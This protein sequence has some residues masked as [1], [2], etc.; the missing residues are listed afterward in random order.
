MAESVFTPT[1]LE[2]LLFT[3]EMAIVLALVAVLVVLFFREVFPVPI[4]ALLSAVVLMATGILTPSEGLSGFSNEATIAVLAMFVLSAGIQ[5]TGAV[6]ALTRR[7]MAWAKGGLRRQIFALSVAA[8]PISGFVN[9]TPVVA[10]LIPAATHMGRE[11]KT[12]PSKLLMPLSSMAMLGGL[13]TV[14]G[15]STN[16]LGNAT[17]RRLGIVPFGFF[18]FTIVGAIALG[19]GLVYYLTIGA[20]LL[21]DR[22]SAD[23][24]NRFDLKGFI[25]EFVVTAEADVVGKTIREAGLGFSQGVQVLRLRRGGVSVDAP[26]PYFKIREGDELVLEAGREKLSKIAADHGLRAASEMKFSLGD[27]EGDYVTAEVVITTGSR[28]VGQTLRQIDF[29]NR[30]E[31]LVLA[32]RHQEHAEIGPLSDRRLRPGDVLLVQAEAESIERMRE[33]PDLY[34]TRERAKATYKSEKLPHALAIVAAVVTVSALG[35]LPISVAGLAGAALMV[36]VGCLDVSQF[37]RSIQLDIIF[38]LAGI[39]PLGLAFEQTG[40]ADLLAVGI[41]EV[42]VY[43]PPVVFLMLLFAVTSLVTEIMSNNASVV[44]LIP[45]AIGAAIALGIDARPVALTVMMA[46]STSMLTPIG[47][48]TNTMVLAPGNY[49]FSDYFRVGGMLNLILAIVIPLAIA[50][51]FPL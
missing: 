32:L 15:T 8:G 47:Y 51:R 7:L 29:R 48:Q 1:L 4:T 21:P 9:N 17:L 42:G 13:L 35:W 46:A 24:I 5:Q 28:Y 27:G 10:V 11:S 43:V 40:L 33:K 23:P 22:G 36:I 18:E 44:L 37:M 12:S 49:R 39:I 16:L 26:R 20:S 31:A 34:V 50:W 38:L 19:V 3:L 6:E 41:A 14:I 45:V 25:G 2:R 30:Y